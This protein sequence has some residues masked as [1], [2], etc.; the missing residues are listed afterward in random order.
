M[1]YTLILSSSPNTDG[2]TAE[3]VERAAEGVKKAGGTV[4]H[5]NLNKMK[6]E[7]CRACDN[8]WGICRKKYECI[9][10]DDFAEIKKDID[11]AAA[12]IIITPVYWGE[13]SESAKCFFDRFRRCEASKYFAGMD[14]D[15]PKS[16]LDDKNAILIAAAGGSGNGTLSCLT[17]MENMIKHVRGKIFDRI[18]VTRF[19]KKYK[20]DTIAEAAYEVVNPSVLK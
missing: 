9:I 18:T 12:V 3:C 8:G 16:A 7:S 2:L 10:K 6:L 20:L 13:M 1:Q 15:S 4:K 14:A 11:S 5:I 19:N 17:Q